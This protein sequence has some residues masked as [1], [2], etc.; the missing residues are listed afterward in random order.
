MLNQ[1][2]GRRP[3]TL[4]YVCTVRKSADKSDGQP[5]RTEYI[6]GLPR[7]AKVSVTPPL[8][9]PSFLSTNFRNCSLKTL[10]VPKWA[11]DVPTCLCNDILERHRYAR[12]L[13][14]HPLSF[15]HLDVV[16]VHT[17]HLL[18]DEQIAEIRIG[19]IIRIDS[20]WSV[21]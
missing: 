14:C 21:F 8:G 15:S 6:E 4:L 7:S 17:V 11:G 3:A 1:Q 13:K 10:Q 9:G 5:P 2:T 12:S 16:L 20:D 19:Y 18:W